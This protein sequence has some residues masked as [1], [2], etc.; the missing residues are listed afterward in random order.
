M[1]SSKAADARTVAPSTEAASIP[2]RDASRPGAQA[3]S[4][5]SAVPEVRS[6]RGDQ[7]LPGLAE[8]VAS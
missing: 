1:L 3:V 6:P 7:P 8:G 5:L 2:R 4:T